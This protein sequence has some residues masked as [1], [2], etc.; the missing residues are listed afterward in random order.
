MKPWMLRFVEESEARMEK[1]MERKIQAV[2]KRLNAFEFIVLERSTPTIDV[3]TFQIELATLCADVDPLLAPD[4]FVPE[5][6][7]EV[8]EDEVVISTLFSDTMPPRDSSRASGKRHRSFVHTSDAEESRR[9]KK[10]ERQELE[11][12]Q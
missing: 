10:R 1:M 11:T 9:A 8:E 2:H 3:T 6:A 12:A 7:P 4:K 5:P